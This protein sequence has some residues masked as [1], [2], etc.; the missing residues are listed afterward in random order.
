MA[1]RTEATPSPAAPLPTREEIL[2]LPKIELHVH[3]EGSIR[4]ATVLALAE[5]NG[6]ALPA[7]TLSELEAFFTFRDFPHFVE[8]YVAVS[9]CVRR[10]ED[11]RRV[12]YDFATGQA[13]QNVLYTEV[14]YTALTIEEHAGIPWSEQ[15]D[16]LAEGFARAREET[17]AEVRLIL[18]VCRNHPVAWGE[19]NLEWTLD[20][21]ARGLVAALG[22]S[23]Q[24]GEF[25]VAP[26]APVF[27]EARRRGVPIAA[28][29]GET[30][31]AESVRETL[32]F[33]VPDRI[34]HGVR[35]VEDVRLVRELVERRIP[36][37]VCPTSNVRLGVFPS[38]EG[39]TLPYLLDAGLLVTINSDDP[40]MF[41]TTLT[42][43]LHR[44]S[45][46][47]GLDRDAL[48]SLTLNAANA[49]FVADERRQELRDVV[50]ENFDPS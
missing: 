19:R 20:G 18:D 1:D 36:L 42:D 32:E 40:P 14:T 37:E 9:K 13:D 31:G 12:A 28:H 23:G 49:A 35:C 2:D 26:H 7:R 41:G 44:A 22:L 50:R 17:G 24:E 5:A 16:A 33:A 27:A 25:P 38:L 8:V 3:L 29:A 34:G 10:P 46:T 30:R 6:I 4:P 15:R 11:L 48:Y 21:H 45:G 43:E 47:F 39:H